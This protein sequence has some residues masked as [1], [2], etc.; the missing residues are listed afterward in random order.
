MSEKQ[1]KYKL[2]GFLAGLGLGTVADAAYAIKT[3]KP[4][5]GWP[6]LV[7][8]GLGLTT[9]AILEK[10]ATKI[11]DPKDFSK[12]NEMAK[13]IAKSGKWP[14]TARVFTNQGQQDL[15]ETKTFAEKYPELV[16]SFY[17][18]LLK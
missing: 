13:E 12:I 6:A 17:K 4:G 8:A 2:K 1:R 7:G 16:S 15:F 9:G 10:K 5:V 18:D 3:N 14:H 11:I